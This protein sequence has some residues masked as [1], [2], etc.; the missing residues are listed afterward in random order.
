MVEIDADTGS[1]ITQRSVGDSVTLQPVIAN[2]TLYL[3]TDSGQL[4][5]YR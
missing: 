2:Q 3:I 5:A 1:Y 4:Q